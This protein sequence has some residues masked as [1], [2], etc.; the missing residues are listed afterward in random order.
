MVM[1]NVLD[2]PRTLI[3][4][5]LSKMCTVDNNLNK[6]AKIQTNAKKN[7]Y[8]INISKVINGLFSVLI[9]ASSLRQRTWNSTGA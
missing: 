1:L 6:Q 5:H 9:T 7:N 3:E 8:L 2:I 4:V